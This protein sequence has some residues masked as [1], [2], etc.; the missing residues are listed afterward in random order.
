[1]RFRAL[2][3]R[4]FSPPKLCQLFDSLVRPGL[5]WGSE[6]WSPALLSCEKEW[7]EGERMHLAFLRRILSVRGSTPNL[8][9]MAELGQYPML[10]H[11]AKL[12]IRFWM[13]LEHL[14]E[15]RLVK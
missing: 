13:R 10:C 15:S 9:V 12:A 8:I 5:E 3:L 4:I 2:Q 11:M 1:M 7:A 6:V 14:D